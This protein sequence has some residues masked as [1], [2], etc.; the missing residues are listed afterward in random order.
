MNPSSA[1]TAVLLDEPRS[2]ARA[3]VLALTIAGLIVLCGLFVYATGG[4][5]YVFSHSMYIPILLGA[6]FFRIPGGV[7]AGAAGGLVL[8]PMMPFETSTGEPQQLVNWLYRTGIFM[9]VGGVAGLAVH[10]LRRQMKRISWLATHDPLSGAPNVVMLSE[11]L[12][13]IIQNGTS[14]RKFVLLVI[15]VENYTEILN[16]LGPSAGSKVSRAVISRLR[17]LMPAGSEP[18]ALAPDRIGA[19]LFEEHSGKEMLERIT[20]GLRAPYP[21]DGLAL[22]VD[23][24]LG[25]SVFPRDGNTP[26]ELIQRASIAMHT[27]A[28]SR[29]PYVEY[30]PT[31]DQT[32]RENLALLGTIANAIESG[33][34]ELHFQPKV[35]LSDFAVTGVEALIRWRHPEKGLIPPGRFIPEVERTALIYPMT[36]WVL[37]RAFATMEAWQ[38]EGVDLSIAVN[39]SARNVQDPLF[40]GQLR[41]MLAGSGLRPES[42]ELEIT[43]SAVMQDIDHAKSVLQ[44]LNRTGILL[45]IDDFGTGHSSLAY[46]HDLPVSIIKID[47]AFVH[48]LDRPDGGQAIV[49]WTSEVAKTLGRSVVAE[50]VE[51]GAVLQAVADLGCH[52]AQGYAVQKPLPCDQF[53]Q[54]YREST[55]RGIWKL[56]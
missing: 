7:L 4:I 40:L 9:A 48:R 54:W 31:A 35:R 17:D 55:D 20:A 16:T 15:Y 28:V 5:K 42:L 24:S 43:E 21:I 56:S 12:K 38:R 53:L 26:E 30:S 3:L 8:G 25:I 36:A 45:S 6:H 11:E 50:G 41:E 2:P 29:R 14:G 51:N 52:Y 47:R 18:C 46:I 23:T 1:L 22:H 19:F 33:Q 39:V 34:F 37:R 10:R 49:R 27:A 32:S 13:R 44:E